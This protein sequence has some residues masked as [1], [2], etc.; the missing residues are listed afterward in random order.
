M[1]INNQINY[2]RVRNKLASVYM[3]EAM[4]NFFYSIFCKSMKFQKESGM[5]EDNLLLFL[6]GEYERRA[7]N[8]MKR[9][10]GDPDVP[11]VGLYLNLKILFPK[12]K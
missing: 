2:D 12:Y 3:N 1:E 6:D 10:A 8:K 7:L 11:Q 9:D 4:V 5:Y